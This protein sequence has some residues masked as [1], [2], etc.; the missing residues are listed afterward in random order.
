[1][2]DDDH[3]IASPFGYDSKSEGSFTAASYQ[4]EGEEGLDASFT[5]KPW[6]RFVQTPFILY[7]IM[8]KNIKMFEFKV[9][10]R[11][12]LFMHAAIHF[13]NILYFF[14][15][16]Y[17]AQPSKNFSIKIYSPIAALNNMYRSL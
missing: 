7:I 1:M 10:Q 17:F 5:S 12:T 14:M 16:L 4:T 15:L 9:A 6:A 3:V 2:Y 8:D 13:Y 11:S